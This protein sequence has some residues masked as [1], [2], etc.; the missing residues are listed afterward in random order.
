MGIL[1]AF[2][3][4]L[5]ASKGACEN[6]DVILIPVHLCMLCLSPL[7]VFRIGSFFLVLEL[8]SDGGCAALPIPL[9]EH[10]TYSPSFCKGCCNPQ[11]ATLF[12]EC[13]G[14]RK[15]PEKTSRESFQRKLPGKT[16]RASS[17]QLPAACRH[18]GP[19][20]SPQLAITLRG[21]PCSR[22]PPGR[23]AAIPH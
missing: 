18:E 20:P 11:L 8:R 15:L 7:E 6:C 19:A 12:R 22:G 4:C 16:S 17:I 14:W 23:R 2:L 10:R 5:L 21:P 1:K 13:L 9:W 3:Y